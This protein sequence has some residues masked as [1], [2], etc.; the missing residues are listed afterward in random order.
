MELDPRFVDVIC[1]RYYKY[2]GRAPV[3]ALTGATFPKK[4][5]DDLTA[6]WE[7]AKDV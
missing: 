4:I 3:H 5:V 6:S 7:E 1:A 2:T